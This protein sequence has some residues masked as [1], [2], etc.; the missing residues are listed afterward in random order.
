M[1]AGRANPHYQ[2]LRNRI[3]SIITQDFSAATEYATVFEEHRKVYTYGQTWNFEA[4]SSKKKY[5]CQLP[6]PAIVSPLFLT[7]LTAHQTMT[8]Q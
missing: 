3:D 4:Y 5:V 8:C 2:D 7:G 1:C 6:Q